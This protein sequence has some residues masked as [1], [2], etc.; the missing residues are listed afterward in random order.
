MNIRRAIVTFVAVLVL[1]AGA[2]AQ[3]PISP[4]LRALLDYYFRGPGASNT[5]DRVQIKDGA[6][7]LSKLDSDS[8]AS[9]FALRSWVVSQILNSGF[10]AAGDVPGLEEDRVWV[11]ER[12][13]YPTFSDLSLY[14]TLT[15]LA[16]QNYLTQNP[17]TNSIWSTINPAA[18]FT[19]AV[20]NRGIGE[21]NRLT[22]QN[23][24]LTGVE[25][26]P[27]L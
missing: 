18:Y 27:G 16:S 22:Y 15:Y 4:Q 9:L 10:V 17:Y 8:V 13:N 24:F 21:T 14:V 5:I 3:A 2:Y 19:G 7:D 20:T 6:I 1:G 26:N 11:A 25:I 23:G 12:G